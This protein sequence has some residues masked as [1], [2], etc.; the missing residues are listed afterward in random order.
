MMIKS[1]FSKL[2]FYMVRL[3]ALNFI[4][5]LLGLLAIVYMFDIVELLRRA[6][7]KDDVGLGDVLALGLYK[8]PEVGQQLFTFAILFSAILTFWQ[9]NRRHELV[10]LRSA[11]LSVWQFIVPIVV[12]ALLIGLLKIMMINPLSAIF[13]SRYEKMEAQILEK[14]T[15][16]I[17]LSKQGLWLRQET[18]EGN[19]ILHAEKIQTPQWHLNKVTIF[20]LSND[21]TFL[22]RLDAP[23]AI[24]EEGQWQIMT[25][26]INQPG[27]VPSSL[28]FVR[29]PTDLTQEKLESSFSSANTVSFWS[30]PNYIETLEKTGFNARPFKIY[31]QALLAQPLLFMA[32][33]LLAA[34][35]SL[36]PTRQH[37]GLLMIVG[38]IGFGFMVFFASNFLQA[39]GAS[40]QIPLFVAG[41]FP[42]IIT[43]LLGIGA[44]MAL[45][46][47]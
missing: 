23:S 15:S 26:I 31:Y 13:L 5:L 38:G 29:M 41:W 11:G 21:D 4:L 39:L 44:L 34:S 42:A 24:L 47:G 37:G 35:V 33:I 32:M 43:F 7:K 45:E 18:Q 36:R 19:A 25:P 12:T 20:Y 46:D 22:R 30:F 28:P 40:G 6:A 2:N 10:I 9:L 14:R 1:P 16:L 17:S 27:S 3:Y 8:L